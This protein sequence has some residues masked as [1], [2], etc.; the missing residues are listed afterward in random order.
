[1]AKRQRIIAPIPSRFGEEK[2]HQLASLLIQAGFAV[3]CGSFKD[4]SKSIYY[5]E[6]WEEGEEDGK[7]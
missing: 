5:V 3:K 7:I 1:M 4:K 2:R 6:F